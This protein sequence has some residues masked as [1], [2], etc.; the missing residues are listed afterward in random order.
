[1]RKGAD[2]ALLSRVS[3][4]SKWINIPPYS[5]LELLK[6]ITNHPD[7]HQYPLYRD[8]MTWIKD[9]GK[10]EK[11]GKLLINISIRALHKDLMRSPKEDGIRCVQDPVG[12]V[13]IS[14]TDLRDN[15]SLNIHPVQEKHK[16]VCG[17]EICIVMEG[18]QR[19]LCEFYLRLVTKLTN[20]D[21]ARDAHYEM[22]AFSDGKHV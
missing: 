10:K 13:L 21:K 14:N 22:A 6:W 12:N 17:R 20:L 7:V 2:G 11:L 8:M 18:Y 19:T 4:R 3:S 9:D 1:M 15:L 16:Q 5:L